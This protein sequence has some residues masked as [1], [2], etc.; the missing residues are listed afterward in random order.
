MVLIED[1]EAREIFDSRG[2]PTVEVDVFLED[3]SFGRAGIPSGASK[4]TYE[5][6]ELRD[7]DPQRLHGRGVSQAVSNVLQEIAPMMVGQDALAQEKID[8]LMI[9][10]DGTENK[11][12]LGA[13]AILGVSLAAARAAADSLGLPLFRYIAGAREPRL[14][15]PMMNVLNGGEHADN[16]VDIQEFMIVP[17]GAPTFHEAVRYCSE[18]FHTLKDMLKEMGLSTSVGDEGGFAPNLKD[19]EQ[20]LAL[21]VTAIKKSGYTPG[22]DIALAIDAAAN[23]FY[24]DGSYSFM[25]DGAVQQMSAADLVA[26]YKDWLNNKD[27]SYPIVSIEDGLAEADDEGWK[28]LTTELGGKIQIVG[29][30]NFVTNP[31]KLRHGIES[32]IANS[33]LIKLN[34]IG[35]VSETLMTMDIAH[36]AG[37]TCVVSHRSGETEDTSIADFATGTACG[38]LKS[39][40]ISRSERVAKYNRLLRIE[41]EYGLELAHWPER[42]QL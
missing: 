40:S 14:P 36:F 9:D 15:L 5:A 11:G 10:L 32:G 1:I 35:T 16:N 33:I 21:L 8:R 2:N 25:I 39:G 29:D 23:S 12:R 31:E 24:K 37:Y 3:G 20:A 30:D 27:E 41:E 13:N 26:V 6:V 28:V 34:Q 4:G 18:V 42:F 38:Q 22:E 19:N 7:N 17:I